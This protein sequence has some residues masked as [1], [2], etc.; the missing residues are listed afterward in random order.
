MDSVDQQL[1]DLLQEDCKMTIKEL[2]QKL[3]LTST[4]V[5]ERIK[6]LEENGYIDSYSAVLNRKKLGLNLQVFCNISL[7]QHQSDS[8]QKFETDILK[9]PEV[10][11]CHHLTGN[12]DYLLMILVEDM[13]SYQHFVTRK[14]A[15]LEDIGKVHS[16]FVMT[17]VKP[18]K[19]YPVKNLNPVL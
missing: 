7:K 19:G 14:L 11:S 15:Q 8:L 2:A 5:F 10:L 6:R 3:N 1:L 12:Y 4:P 9:F 17:E 18:F 13:E 16:Q